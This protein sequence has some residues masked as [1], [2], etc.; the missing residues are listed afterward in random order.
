MVLFSAFS[1]FALTV[2]GSLAQELTE[3]S[4]RDATGDSKCSTNMCI[5]AVLNGSTVQYTM[6]GTGKR[7]VGWMGMG[8][9]TQMA[10]TP[11]VIMWG[12]SDGTVTLSQRQAAAE[13]MPTVVS[14][15]PRV[16][17]VSE[18]LS[19]T[20]GNSAFV[21][22][23]PANSDTTQSLIFAFSTTNPDSTDESANIVQHVDYGVMSLDLT[24]SLSSSTT[25]G[26]SSTS[27]GTSGSSSDSGDTATGATDDIP[28]TPYQRMIV[29]HAV[30]CVAGFALLLPTGV[31]L[32]RYLRTFSPSWYT[33]HWIAQFGIAGPTIITGVA[34]G[35][36]ASGPVGYTIMDPHKKMGI[37]IFSLYCVQCV[38]GAL[39]HYVKPK[40][41]TGRP[42]QNYFHAVFGLTIIALAMYQIRTGY[43]TEWAYTGLAS[44]PSSVNI[45][46][47]LWVILLPIL[48]A[49]GI[50]LFLK[51]QYRQEDEYRKGWK[52]VNGYSMS[53]TNL[54]STGG[55]Y[56][57]Q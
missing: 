45:I 53:S 56:Y 12:N 47:T 27:T 21:Y 14:S 1:L 33:G 54:H 48:Y 30:F 3:F 55:G 8:F 9:G 41:S 24:K 32:A 40:N 18:T 36:K 15:P 11:M 51:K 29:A 39:I 57:D 4:K 37:I 22:T 26:S 5:A 35:F 17:T 31:L 43:K 34:L 50:L 2:S 13:V 28:L 23:I 6:S 49:V 52:D 42:P 46:W 19:T 16:A 7:T 44:V 10:N 20:S 38:V 25:T